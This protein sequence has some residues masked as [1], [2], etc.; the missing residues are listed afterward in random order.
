MSKLRRHHKHRW[1]YSTIT[2]PADSYPNTDEG[3]DAF[4]DFG[5]NMGASIGYRNENG[6]W[7]IMGRKMRPGQCKHK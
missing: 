1:F 7:E 5:C 6:G 3:W 2:L 4:G